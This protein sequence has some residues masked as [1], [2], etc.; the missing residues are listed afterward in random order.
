MQMYAK[1]ENQ[2]EQNL[3]DMPH[4]LDFLILI[5]FQLKQLTE[6]WMESTSM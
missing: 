1:W 3:W 6:D 5:D 2:F 4:K